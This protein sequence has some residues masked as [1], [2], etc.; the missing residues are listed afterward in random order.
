MMCRSESESSLYTLDFRM[1]LDIGRRKYIEKAEET[2]M[3]SRVSCRKRNLRLRRRTAAFR[4]LV[5]FVVFR[6][7][8]EAKT[9]FSS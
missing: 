1:T 9:K 4:D 8:S 7:I 5:A 2:E 6:W 3:R